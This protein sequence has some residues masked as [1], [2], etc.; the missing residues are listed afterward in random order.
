[1]CAE[2]LE[3][4][5][6]LLSAVSG[7]LVPPPLPQGILPFFL[8]EARQHTLAALGSVLGEVESPPKRTQKN[9]TLANLSEPE[10]LRH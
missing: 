4:R 6:K 5:F 1:M 8:A 2:F 7:W 10:R 3:G 9:H